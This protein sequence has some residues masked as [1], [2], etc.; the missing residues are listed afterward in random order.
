M[1][2][3]MEPNVNFRELTC[4]V[5]SN[6]DHDLIRRVAAQ[7][8]PKAKRP[9]YYGKLE[10]GAV[11]YSAN[12]LDRLEP[13]W[14]AKVNPLT[15]NL[16]SFKLCVLGQVFGNYV[17]GLHCWNESTKPGGVDVFVGSGV[18][19]THLVKKAWRREVRARR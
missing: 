1:T 5:P 12:Y 9:R 6:L 2:D 10:A 15:L 8:R 13:G 18:I 19:K 17:T 4:E 3:L 7:Q 14:A 16:K 11:A